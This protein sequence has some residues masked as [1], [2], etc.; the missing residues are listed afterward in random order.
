VLVAVELE[1]E[2][3]VVVDVI[4]NQVEVP[5]PLEQ[6][7]HIGSKRHFMKKNVNNEIFCDKCN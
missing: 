2:L 5:F 3:D 6:S 4:R 1:W 7:D